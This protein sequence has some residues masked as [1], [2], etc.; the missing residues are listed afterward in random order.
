MK[1]CG[2][3]PST[4]SRE[5]ILAE[6]TRLQVL[7]NM[8][9]NEEQAIKIFINSMYGATAS[10][11]FVGYNVR[12]AEAITLQGQEMIKFVTKIINRYFTEFWHR[13]TELHEKLG[14]TRAEKITREAAVY[15]DTD[16]CYV[17]FQDAVFGC[18]WDKDPRKLI[19]GI[20][21]YRL[22]D[23]LEKAFDKLSQ[24]MGTE[25]IQN[26]E[27]ETV[28][29]SAIFLKKKKYVLDIS[30]KSGGGDGIEYAPGSKIKA[31]GVEIVQSSTPL[32]A[33]NKLKELLK[34]ILNEKN[35]LNMRSFAELLKREKAAF[36][37]DQVENVSMSC[38]VNDYEKG[39]LN[40]RKSLEINSGCPMHVRAAG[41][42][43]HLLNSS[44][45]KGKYQLIKSGDKVRYYYAQN[46]YG[47]ENV[48]AYL[49]G[50]HP[51]EFAP[52]IDYEMQ[53]AKC[54]V[55][56]INRFISAMGMP[57][58]SSEL[59]VKTQLF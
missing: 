29:Y 31:T 27:M 57:P 58:L 19:L 56:P 22:K 59:I 38:N 53:F 15:G 17:T 21:N 37:L 16:S 11:Y 28:S 43:N 55:D 13:D 12:V 14:I 33:R 40:D 5:E 24:S 47:G 46:R 18:D 3:D 45:W 54:I 1:H 44:K 10:P 48:F 39:I 51:V 35:K 23:Y 50:N 42:H 41:F 6:I 2:I 26:L 30:W 32:F 9:S 20:Y 52:P 25:N 4:S 49:P 34:V 7:M 8:R 36:M